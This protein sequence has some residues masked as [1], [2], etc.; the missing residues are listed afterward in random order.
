MIK[1]LF[2]VLVCVCCFFAV[3]VY[4]QE[5]PTVTVDSTNFT[6]DIPYAEYEDEEGDT[7]ALSAELTA[8]VDTSDFT[9]TLNTTTLSDVAVDAPASVEGDGACSQTTNAQFLSCRSDVQDDFFEKQA[10]CFNFSDEE[11]RSECFA[12]AEEERLEGLE[13]CDDIEEAHENLCAVLGEDPYDPDLDD[14]TFV[15]LD[16]I[17]ANPNPY[18]PLVVGNT[19][20][21]ENDEETITVTV[22]DQTREIDGV[23][24]IVVQD[25][26]M[27]EGELVEDTF[28]WYAQDDEGNVW[29]MGELSRNYEDGEL[30]DIDGSWEAGEEGAKA[31]I[32]FRAMPIVDEVLRQEY[33]IGEAE[34]I[35]QTVRLDSD[36]S[37]DSG[38]ECNS[39]CLETL[40]STPLEPEALETKIYLPGTGLL[41]EIDLEEDS[42]IELS[43]FIPGN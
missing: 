28:D 1:Q 16:D 7:K 23:E 2:L 40:E 35:G 38:F 22:L 17:A 15:S 9:F 8:P 4:A 27:E 42:R 11:E 24:A 20:V 39:N 6:I 29:Y 43:E 37:T 10:V 33:A 18:F 3:G 12:E 14:I 30:S 21:Y 34:D 32:L 19:W 5:Y 13:E 31:G 25:V 36:E 26:V 41:M